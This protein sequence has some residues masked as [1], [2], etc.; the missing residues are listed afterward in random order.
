MPMYFGSSGMPIYP[1]GCSPLYPSGFVEVGHDSHAIAMMERMISEIAPEA[2]PV[3]ANKKV[4]TSK[5]A[6]GSRSDDRQTSMSN[7]ELDA[8]IRV[9]PRNRHTVGKDYPGGM[10]MTMAAA[11]FSTSMRCQAERW[12]TLLVSYKDIRNNVVP[13]LKN[14]VPSSKDAIKKDTA[15]HV[16]DDDMP[17]LEQIFCSPME[18]ME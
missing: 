18:T 15:D 3:E 13:S 10:H 4:K 2:M 14:Y 5:D 17:E 8:K 7:T 1:M 6:S 11:G 12:E 16:G 9:T